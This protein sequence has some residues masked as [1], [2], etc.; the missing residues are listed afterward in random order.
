MGGALTTF[1][2]GGTPTTA[3]TA[4]LF[5]NATATA[6]TKTINIGPN[7]A[8]GSDTLIALGTNTSGAN[9]QV[10]IAS[11]VSSRVRLGVGRAALGGST[12]FSVI[13]VGTGATIVGSKQATDATF[14]SNVFFDGTWKH[15]TGS[16]NA[17]NMAFTN[18]TGISFS[19]A[20][21]ATL[22][23]AVTWT[24]FLTLLS[25][26]IVGN[27]TQDL[28]N[29]VS[30]A[31][32]FAGAATTLNIGATTGTMNLR[33]ATIALT[34][35]PANDAGFTTSNLLVRDSTGNLDKLA[36]SGGGTTNFLRADGTWAAP[37]GG[38]SGDV[39]GPASAVDNAIAR[40]DTTTGKLIQ[41]SIVTIN[42]SGDIVIGATDAGS[43]RLIEASSS[44][45]TA[46]LSLRAKGTLG[47]VQ[48]E[49]DGR[50]LSIAA[51][52]STSL[53]LRPGNIGGIGNEFI[54]SGGI[55][56]TTRAGTLTLLGGATTG[57]AVVD[58]GSIILGIQTPASTG[59]YGNVALINNGATAPN[60]QSMELGLFIAAMDAAPIGNPAG[61]VFMYNDANDIKVRRTDADI[62][63]LTRVNA[64]WTAFTTP[65][66][67]LKTLN[68]ASY[69]MDE[70]MRIVYTLVEEL[71]T[72]GMIKA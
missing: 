18:A 29:T 27:A 37:G 38:G 53:R 64:G 57:G 60:F 15:S 56:D 49:V 30:T 42:D 28:F 54:I 45:A 6:T 35:V 19:S 20:P 48:F 7:G 62:V 13:E 21:A 10:T 44:G 63:N 2:L 26:S 69:T 24:T 47:I 12:T 58:S 3:L 72:R 32:N 40:F 66:T 8:S 25:G 33:N 50:L 5:G 70:L 9:I 46:N 11:A 67:T 68:A 71:R 22:N 4:T 39:V 17:Y 16:G 61:G 52:S 14:G 55:G 36:A 31:I 65:P 43:S 59:K 23:T 51:P 41:N 1:T 34:Q